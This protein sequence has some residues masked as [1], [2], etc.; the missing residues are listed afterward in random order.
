MINKIL[1]KPEARSITN[2]EK[3]HK[4]QQATMVAQIL[5]KSSF[6]KDDLIVN[7]SKKD[8]NRLHLLHSLIISRK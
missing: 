8:L 7:F 3:K 1:A 4:I 2:G 6:T 5:T